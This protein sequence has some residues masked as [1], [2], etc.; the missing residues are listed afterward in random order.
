MH[1]RREGMPGKNSTAKR[2]S[3]KADDIG[4]LTFIDGFLRMP[5]PFFYTFT[6]H[7]RASVTPTRVHTRLLAYRLPSDAMLL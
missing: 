1:D 2:H 3:Q 7:A 6:G 5:Y 4:R